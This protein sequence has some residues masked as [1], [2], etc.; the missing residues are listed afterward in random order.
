MSIIIF[1]MTCK[2]C[3]KNVVWYKNI[4]DTIWYC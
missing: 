2:L 4:K 1:E 3:E